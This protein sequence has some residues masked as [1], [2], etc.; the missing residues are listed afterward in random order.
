M[1]KKTVCYLI[2][3]I[4]SFSVFCF[5]VSAHDRAEHEKDLR[6]VLFGPPC[7]L[8]SI[9]VDAKTAMDKLYHASYLS[10]DQFNG[11]GKEDLT[12]LK[13]AKIKWLP[14]SI[15]D[16]DFPASGHT[17]RSFTHRGWNFDYSGD[18][19]ANW[20]ARK[21]ILLSTVNDIFKFKHTS[22]NPDNYKGQCESFAALIYYIHL[23]GDQI[24]NKK[25][26]AEGLEMNLGGTKD[27]KNVIDELLVFLPN[28][29]PTQKSSGTYT[30]LTNRLNQLN[31]RISA[32]VNKTGG[33]RSDE[34]FAEYHECAEELMNILKLHIPYLLRNEPFFNKV[35]YK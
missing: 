24:E 7:N 14:K 6:C 22:N 16:I 10:I 23:I 21:M 27:K 2:V 33:I 28:L 35:F 8:P 15:D 32:L 30:I 18:D 31:T 1:M 13:N 5:S 17:H 9:S 20:P 11:Y 4:F 29:F 34:D 12:Y 25:I 3:I 26:K 19:Q